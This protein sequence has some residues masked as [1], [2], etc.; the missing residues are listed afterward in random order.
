MHW[1]FSL[2]NH[3]EY[4]FYKFPKLLKKETKVILINARLTI[5]QNILDQLR[6]VPWS[7]DPS[8]IQMENHC[9]LESGVNGS[10]QQ[11]IF[12]VYLSIFFSLTHAVEY[13]SSGPT[14]VSCHGMMTTKIS[15]SHPGEQPL[16]QFI[17]HQWSL[18]LIPPD[19]IHPESP[20][21][22][23]EEEDSLHLSRRRTMDMA[24]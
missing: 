10:D 13:H 9:N 23:D 14:A 16:W 2:L 6:H 3:K 1:V 15:Y 18:A 17:L 22:H 8:H 19:I 20:P 12:I 7:N 24:G 11:I 5:K 4:M 21:Y